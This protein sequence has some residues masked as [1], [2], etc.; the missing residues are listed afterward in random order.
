MHPSAYRPISRRAR[1]ISE[2]VA[3][4]AA[5][6]GLAVVLF[7]AAMTTNLNYDEEQYVAGAYF[8]RGLSLYRDFI[9]FQP[10]PYTWI[11]AA[12][13]DAL[14]GWYLLAARVVT[15]VFAFGTCVLL[16]SLL[17][18]FRTGRVGAFAL[19]L[20]FLTSPFTVG[21]LVL[22]RNDIMPLFF[23]LLGLRLWLGPDGEI[24]RSAARIMLS[25]F[26]MALA[27]ATKYSYVFAPPVVGAALLYDEYVR[28]EAK[29]PFSAP[30]TR[31]FLA[32][33]TLGVLPLIY[34]LAVHQERFVF[35]T[36]LFHL[37]AVHDWYRSQGL[38]ELLTLQ[39]KVKSLPRQII[40]HGNA[41][42]FFIFAFSAIALTFTFRRSWALWRTYRSD[43]RAITLLVLFF[44]AL[45]FATLVG[46]H[47]MYFAPVTALG[48]LL[49]GPIYAAA[50]PSI[51]RWLTATLL[52]ISLAPAAPA[53]MRYGRLLL[54]SADLGQW[55]GI[56]THRSAI[57]I[58]QILAQHA[59]SGHV[60]TLFPIVVMDVNPGA[61]RIRCGTVLLSQRG[62]LFRSTGRTTARGRAGHA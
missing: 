59:V 21:P 42:I 55:T 29:W 30:R 7:A 43:P 38:G 52:I 54:R 57:R 22:T 8:A 44:S 19:L 37:T 39:H 50:R 60:A 41:T 48:M 49:T 4:P 36:L 27:V 14:G 28:G 31:W 26:F 40:R 24:S 11:L 46:P 34:S 35:S 6:V 33:A 16:F 25:G 1:L 56:Q 9:S 12:L 20:G 23:F 13:F 15:F 53:F 61:S 45:G 32:G 5:L 18:S 17:I 10:P 58:A 47:A 3:L 62:H 51:P 2:Q